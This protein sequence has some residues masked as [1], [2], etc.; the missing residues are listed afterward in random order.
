LAK[1]HK[2]DK[3]LDHVAADSA[4][5]EKKRNKAYDKEIARLQVEIACLQSWVQVSGARIVI[6]FEGRDAA[7]KGG[8]VKRFVERVSQRVFRVAALPAPRD[9]EKSQMYFHRYMAQTASGRRGRDFRS[10]LVQPHRR[11]A[12]VGLHL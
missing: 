7:G 11:G 8:V 4:E 2:N 6:I 3:R 9:R 5:A 12:A 10:L 1:K